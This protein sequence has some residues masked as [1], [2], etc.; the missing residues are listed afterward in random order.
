M[1]KAPNSPPKQIPKSYLTEIGKAILPASEKFLS[2]WISALFPNKKISRFFY[3]QGTIKCAPLTYDLTI[4]TAVCNKQDKYLL[5]R[6]YSIEHEIFRNEEDISEHLTRAISCPPCVPHI[7]DKKQ[8]SDYI[9]FENGRITDIIIRKPDLPKEDYGVNNIFAQQYTMNHL[10][11]YLQE[12]LPSFEEHYLKNARE[13]F[14]EYGKAFRNDPNLI[15]G[16]PSK[17]SIIMTCKQG[18]KYIS[19][20]L[21]LTVNY[22]K[23]YQIQ[24]DTQMRISGEKRFG[25]LHTVI[26]TAFKR[27]E[28]TL[29]YA[30][31]S[32]LKR[33]AICE[34]Q[35]YKLPEAFYQLASIKRQNNAP[36]RIICHGLDKLI[37]QYDNHYLFAGYKQGRNIILTT[38]PLGRSTSS[39]YIGQE[40]NAPTRFTLDSNAPFPTSPIMVISLWE[41]V[42]KLYEEMV[43]KISYPFP[44]IDF[45]MDFFGNWE[46]SYRGQAKGIVIPQFQGMSA[47]ERINTV[48]RRIS[49][50]YQKEVRILERQIEILN[51]LNHTEIKILKCL[52]D[53]RAQN[54]DSEAHITAIT[55][56]IGDLQTTKS[57]IIEFVDALENIAVEYDGKDI[58]LVESCQA[59]NYY[60]DYLVYSTPIK[61]D[62]KAFNQATPRP[63]TADELHMVKSEFRTINFEAM[64][65]SAIDDE[66][67]WNIIS[68]LENCMSKQYAIK[69]VKSERGKQFFCSFSGDDAIYAKFFIEGL[70][71]CKKL[72]A[73]LYPDL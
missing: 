41:Q 14:K 30:M 52:F 71:G 69:F 66:S 62:I 59:S 24:E 49:E 32:I 58:H 36:I 23:Q 56:S 2:S 28:D 55:E 46:W 67:R 37:N 65:D 6:T 68:H 57:S 63:F 5:R 53:M 38:N 42:T 72:A 27:L 50:D 1:K 35:N 61:W 21:S 31:N 8:T 40:I 48:F 60:G 26:Q 11:K 29:D 47:R 4:Q 16:K 45:R 18:K 44:K 25:D 12:S 3:A 43:S 51:S 22:T 20:T 33:A 70:P 64:L 54:K 73:E 39:T 13:H 7:T 17:C 19:V 9:L 34:V 15:I 10:Y